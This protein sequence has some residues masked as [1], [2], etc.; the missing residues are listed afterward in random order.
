MNYSK[1]YLSGQ[2]TAF[3]ISIVHLINE[4]IYQLHD[5]V[6]TQSGFIRHFQ[7]IFNMRI[8]SW[9]C[10]QHN[11]H[12]NNRKKPALTRVQ[13]PKPAMFLRLVP[14]TFDPKINGFPGLMVEHFSV[15]FGDPSCS[16]F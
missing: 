5:I 14:M 13:N 4:S 10:S 6:V 7:Q 16:G 3:Q 2:Y 11:I 9:H 8:T 1:P 12:N 15:T